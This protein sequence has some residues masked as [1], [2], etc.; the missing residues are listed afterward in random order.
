M[1]CESIGKLVCGS[2]NGE[3]EAVRRES[4][5]PEQLK[6]TCAWI[7]KNAFF[8]HGVVSFTVT[9]AS[10][11]FAASW[12][13]LLP[14]I[15]VCAAVAFVASNVALFLFRNE[16]S[17]N[18]VAPPEEYGND[19]PLFSKKYLWIVLTER[20]PLD[21]ALDA[22]GCIPVVNVAV[23]GSEAVISEVLLIYS[24][25][26]SL[27]QI[28][29]KTRQNSNDERRL[30]E[31]IDSLKRE[32]KETTNE[33]QS[34]NEAVV[35]SNAELERIIDFL[36]KNNKPQENEEDLEEGLQS[37]QKKV[38]LGREQLEQSRLIAEEAS[39]VLNEAVKR[40]EELNVLLEGNKGQFEEMQKKRKEIKNQILN[41]AYYYK[42]L[43]LGCLRL[44]L[45][46]GTAIGAVGLSAHSYQYFQKNKSI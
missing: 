40:R 14:E 29:F 26:Q 19:V 41:C 46:T 2:F 16:I 20:R 4:L 11:F 21:D 24:L 34:G 37:I 9:S 13:V 3:G 10:I 32:I 30:K 27:F 17:H 12:F 31:S 5:L 8:Q 33:V 22:L 39:Q 25:F 36:K 23:G 43:I 7:S 45:Y 28:I 44:N 15:T 1:L 42:H 35:N 18:T 6:K 38:Q